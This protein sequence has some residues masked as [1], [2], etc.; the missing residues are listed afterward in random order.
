MKY[1][2]IILEK[3]EYVYLKRILNISGYAKDYTVQNSLIK[4]LEEI[5]KAQ[6][7][8]DNDVPK[9]VVRFNSIVAIASNDGWKKELQVVIP[10]DKDL[11]LNKI[12]V[13]AP[14]GTA[15]LGYAKGDVVDWD[16]PRGKQQ[17]SIVDVKQEESLKGIDVII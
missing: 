1:G 15:L 9:D 8:D 10:K 17:V 13:L 16:L 6:I 2:N 12:S 11:T 3:K 5:K 14:M 7:L 4:L